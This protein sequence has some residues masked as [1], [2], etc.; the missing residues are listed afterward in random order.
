M[1][2]G[3]ERALWDADIV[4]TRRRA[5]ISPPGEDRLLQVIDTVSAAFQ[6][7]PPHLQ[8]DGSGGGMNQVVAQRDLY[9]RARA[10]GNRDVAR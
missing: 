5:L 7:Q 1:G 6:A 3:A 8:Q 2:G 9:H 4:G 10:L